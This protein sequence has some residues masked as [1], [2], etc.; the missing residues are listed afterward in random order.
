MEFIQ[1]INEIERGKKY[2]KDSF[3]S[4]SCFMYV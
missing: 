1:F 3:N 2:E 4:I